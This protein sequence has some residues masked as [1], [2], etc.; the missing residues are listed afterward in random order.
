M[1]MKL[2]QTVSAAMNETCFTNEPREKEKA[3]RGSVEVSTSISKV[4]SND[5]DDPLSS[6]QY[7]V[8][9]F[10]RIEVRLPGNQ[11]SWEESKGRG[12]RLIYHCCFITS[13]QLYMGLLL[14]AQPAAKA[15]ARLSFG[16]YRTSIKQVHF[17]VYIQ[18][19]VPFSSLVQ[20]L[21]DELE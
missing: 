19:I 8:L 15:C 16:Y 9:R 20:Y 18:S 7:V 10:I 3:F 2:S 4:E 17:S 11:K 13:L 5:P 14:R 6:A 21:S 12:R 1:L